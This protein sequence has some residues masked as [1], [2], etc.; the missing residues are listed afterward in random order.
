M[1]S[2]NRSV[3][4]WLFIGCLLIFLMVIIGGITRLTGSGL[5]I[6]E[7]KL[8]RGTIPPLNETQWNEEFE[9]YKQIPQYKELNYNYTLADFKKIY[10]WEYIHRLIG[11][12]IGI[13]FIVPFLY[14]FFTK[15]LNRELI[16]KLL[17]LFFLG[18]LQGLLGWYM[19][20]SGLVN[21]VHV[22]H[23]RLA[24]HLITAFI[25]FGFTFWILLEIICPE[26]KSENPLTATLRKMSFFIFFL[27]IMQIIY[28]AFVAGLK[29]GHIYN[30]FPKMGEEWVASSVT[31]GLQMEGVKSL[32][33]NISV[34]Q[35]LHRYIAWLLA[36]TVVMVF[37]YGKNKNHKAGKSL[38][39]ARQINAMNFLFIA[40]VI[41]FLLGTFT[42][43]YNVPVVLGVLHQAG[44][45]FLFS[46]SLFFVYSV[47]K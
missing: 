14:F 43:I 27:V 33:N 12:V 6:T 11:R 8:I 26:K 18:G 5:S 36:L 28:G 47:R 3:V 9:N 23:L 42:L 45:F 10:W 2:S 41:Q 15:Q 46:N 30:T 22:S 24:A 17:F 20:K 13:V 34:V 7:W 31:Y 1:K 25:T 16:K 21:N 44:A 19:V 38:M 4:L 35:F 29:A 32:V 40:I 39:S 37:Y